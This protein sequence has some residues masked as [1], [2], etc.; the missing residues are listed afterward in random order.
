MTDITQL[1]RPVEAARFFRTVL[2]A[3]ATPA[4]PH[5]VGNLPDVPAPLFGSSAAIILALADYQTPVW[6][7]PRFNAETVRKFIRFHTGAP[8]TQDA[9]AAVF[10]VLDQAE[11]LEHID[12][13]S[14]GA[15]EY[16]DRSATLVVQVGEVE[17]LSQVEA[18]G[19]GLKQAAAFGVAGASPVF[20]QRLQMNAT[21]FP[22]GLD[23]IFAAPAAI[24]SLPRSTRLAVKE[25]R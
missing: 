18:S 20:W 22:L 23:F 24:A 12:L 17:G 21:L 10:A 16:P 8:I 25:A 3:F 1:Q 4:T 2:S 5:D 15:E 6:L 7:S 19:P 11:L 14:I 13:F 9:K